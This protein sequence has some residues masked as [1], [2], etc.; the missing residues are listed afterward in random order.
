MV[1]PQG[2]NMAALQSMTAGMSALKQ[3]AESGGFAISK[4]G[5]DAYIHAIKTALE[6]LDGIQY[7]TELLQQRTKL[8]TS[9]DA[10]RMSEYNL[11]N[12]LGG[13]G[14]IGLIPAIDQLKIALGEALQ[15]MQKAKENY[16]AVDD[17][18]VE[19]FNSQ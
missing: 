8:G 7:Q 6:Q 12:A 15:A 5:A 13:P 9:P 14:T 10:V 1:I 17:A 19:K 2:L 3:T 4:S 16:S 18:R 11:E